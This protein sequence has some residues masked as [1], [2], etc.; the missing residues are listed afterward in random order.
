ML[1]AL[2]ATLIDAMEER[3]DGNMRFFNFD[4]LWA[5][6]AAARVH[7]PVQLVGAER[8]FLRSATPRPRKELEGHRRHWQ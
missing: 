4:M 5:M 1:F 7:E 6:V 2:P 3:E 8:R